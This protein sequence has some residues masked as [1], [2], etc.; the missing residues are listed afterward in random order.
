MLVAVALVE[1]I[2]KEVSL[3]QVVLVEEGTVVQLLAQV[4][5]VLLLQQVLQILAAAVAEVGVQHQTIN[6]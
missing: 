6:L 2:I 1:I 5:E 4:L 3:V